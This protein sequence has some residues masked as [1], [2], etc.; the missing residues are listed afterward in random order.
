MRFRN[1]KVQTDS[2]SLTD[3]SPRKSLKKF[4][5]QV[6]FKSCF[7]TKSSRKNSNTNY[8]HLPT[9]ALISQ[10]LDKVSAALTSGALSG[11]FHEL[12]KGIVVEATPDLSVKS[13]SVR[14]L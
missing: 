6:C 7:V 9:R 12:P 14:E 8:F 4:T 10:A 11:Y 1:Y 3:C 5:T 2:V 13:S